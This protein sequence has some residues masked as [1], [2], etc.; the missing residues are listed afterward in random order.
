MRDEEKKSFSLRIFTAQ[1]I[2]AF[3]FLF[4]VG[5]VELFF[6]LYNP[7]FASPD[8]LSHLQYSRF[9]RETGRMPNPYNE[10][11][12]VQQDKHPPYAYFLGALVL[13]D[14]QVGEGGKIYHLPGK[15]EIPM[16][17]GAVSKG[18]G[19]SNLR[20]FLLR[21]LM[22]IHWLFGSFFLWK[23]ARL[24]WPNL[25]LFSFGIAL[26]FSTIPQVARIGASFSPD[27]PLMAFAAISFYYLASLVRAWSSRRALLAGFFM[28]LALLSKSAAVC[29][30]PLPFLICLFFQ[31]KKPLGFRIQ[32][33]AL[34]FGPP[35]LLASWW[36][37]RN[38]YLFGDPFQMIA[39]M[40][41]FSHSLRRSPVTPVFYEVFFE[42]LWRTFVGFDGRETLIP[43]PF[44]Y[45]LA[46]LLGIAAAGGGLLVR[47]SGREDVCHFQ[48]RI[49]VL[50]GV[51][52]LAMLGLTFMGNLSFHSPQ[53][54]YLFPM[55]GGGMVLCGV[56]WR[57]ALRLGTKDSFV[58]PLLGLA[59]GGLGILFFNYSFLPKFYPQKARIEN[60]GGDV[61]FY[62][63]CGTPQ[64]HPHRIQG[65]DIPDGSQEG[66][67]IPWRTLDGH[68][69]KV[70]YRFQI[71]ESQKK[72]LQIR[73]LYFNPDPRT[74]FIAKQKGHFVYSSQR[75]RVNGFL[76][77]DSIEVT[78]TPS[79]FVFPIPEKWIV[80][81]V[82]ELSI[83][84]VQGLAATVAEI[85][86]EKRWISLEGSGPKSFLQN[87]SS[88]PLDCVVFFRDKKSEYVKRVLLAPGVNPLS[89]IGLSSN[90][91]VSVYLAT[92]SPLALIQAESF[93]RG[94]ATWYG[95]I[96]AEGGFF[97][98]G[99]GVLCQIPEKFLL[100]K[101][102]RGF[103]F[104]VRRERGRWNWVGWR[105]GLIVPRFPLDLSNS[106]AVK[107]G[108]RAE[109]D[110]DA[111]Q[112]ID[113]SLANQLK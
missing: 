99:E 82:L 69:E 76:I 33:M 27:S 41:T 85:W 30:L 55:L 90:G 112:I 97:L 40:E 105:A 54:R 26:G 19:I 29:L 83:E 52:F 8:E 67:I 18:S 46:G 36:Y 68:P 9:L 59:W 51:G 103:L 49:L 62:E 25:H 14:E 74:P 77:H 75:L 78:S 34:I 12:K 87:S 16:D 73:V 84:K 38:Y 43:H 98:R 71:T 32:G 37:I 42:D 102:E 65:F 4:A 64:L 92:M 17:F 10:R 109:T 2:G 63:D 100:K 22:A 13:G 1:R 7:P 50:G 95:A 3:C 94:S 86:I 106:G 45:L 57:V 23:L 53:G 31:R 113:F 66:R 108:D 96:D 44:Y 111:I 72:H 5:L 70:V 48:L 80:S 24:M 28:G 35:I 61:Y 11:V 56:G 60:M 91:L 79:T 93:P 81:G 104:R 110:L 101:K 107:I 39:Q 21:G 88:S 15:F 6:V 20:L 89:S 58:S 47:R